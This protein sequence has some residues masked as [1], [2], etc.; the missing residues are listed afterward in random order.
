MSPFSDKLNNW[1]DNGVTGGAVISFVAFADVSEVCVI[2]VTGTVVF[3]RFCVAII[4]NVRTFREWPF[5]E[6][7]AG[8]RVSK[9]II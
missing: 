8:S 2:V 3:A 1:F 9:C 6:N 4:D 7:V 5:G